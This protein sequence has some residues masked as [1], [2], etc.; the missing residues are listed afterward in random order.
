MCEIIFNT[1]A[2]LVFTLTYER[3]F[4]E[5]CGKYLQDGI[6]RVGIFGLV[7]LNENQSYN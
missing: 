1:V 5:Y 7:S 3:I 4:D 6:F 2:Y